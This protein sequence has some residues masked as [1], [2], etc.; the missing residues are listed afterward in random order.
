MRAM[1]WFVGGLLATVALASA[2]VACWPQNALPLA[3]APFSAAPVTALSG[4]PAPANAAVP[5]AVTAPAAK[6]TAVAAPRVVMI[7]FDGASHHLAEQFI[8]EGRMPWAKKLMEQGSFLPLGSANP[9]E[10]PV[11]W[12]SV[13]SGQNP[14]KTNIFGFIRRTFRWSEIMDDQ[15]QPKLIGSVIPT[16]GYS[17]E[18]DLPWKD[19]FTMPSHQNDLA[20]KNFWDLLDAANLSSRVLQV[21][22]NYPAAAGPNTKLLAGLSVPDVRGGPGTYLV[23]TNSEWDFPRPTG[24]G[25][26]VMKF[27]TICPKCKNK[28]FTFTKG[29]S[30]CA[31]GNKIGYFETKLSGPENFVEAQKWARKVKEIEDKWKAVEPGTAEHQTLTKELNT[32]KNDKKKWEGEKGNASVPLVGWV[33]KA[34]KTIKFAL[35]GREVT[36]AEGE[37]APYIPVTFEIENAFAMKATAHLHVSQCNPDAEDVKFYLPAITVATDGMPP[38]MPVTSP[39]AFGAELVKD[40]GYFD[41]IGWS[42]QTHALKDDEIGDLSFMS[43]IW[44]TIQWRRKMLEAQL[45]KNDWT[46]LFQVFG[47]TDRVCHMMYRFFDEKHPQWKAEE[48]NKTIRFGPQTILAKDAIPAIYAEVDKTIGI[49]MQRIESGSLGDCT[50]MVC[51]DHGFS[52]F[53]E[54]VELNAWLIDQGFMTLRKEPDGKPTTNKQFLMY[55]DWEK[56]KAYSVGIGNIYVNLKGREPNGSVD[57]ADYDAVCDQM[58]AKM[59]AYRNP[60]ETTSNDRQVFKGAWK[61]GDYLAGPFA[62]DLRDAKGRCTEGA[63]DIQVGFNF[64]YRVGW[65]T[66]MGD[67]SK[68][69][70]VFPNKNR[71][72]G[73]HTSVHPYLV[74]GIF[75]SNKKVAAGAAPHLQ[76]LAATILAIHGVPVPDDMDGHV[77]PLAGLE[78]KAKA[79]VGGRANRESLVAPE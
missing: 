17:R 19:G 32:A 37:W 55:V 31:D 34:N 54:E 72:S 26:Q 52:P 6:A 38:N 49:V 15:K 30:K 65:G 11:A 7:G 56:T 47:E 1:H 27:R 28:S 8:A 43:A 53:R 63:A 70:I 76:D 44:D 35:A 78:A 22:C 69:A 42:C 12:A 5:T 48:A 4:D 64:G 46:T 2:A 59:L 29:C 18:A 41:T 40:V 3:A 58:I 67:R 14:G 79:H 60:N 62:T 25:G 33:D 9:A 45:D 39:V 20:V 24:N 61:R 36:L 66:A 68:E 75:F 21:A 74:R 77:I 50:L 73:D 13:N 71:W 16:I 57:A 10:S 51:S 23:Y